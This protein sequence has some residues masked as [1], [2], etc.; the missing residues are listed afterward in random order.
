GVAGAGGGLSWP[1]QRAGPGR[2]GC[3]HDT[4]LHDAGTVGSSR[5]DAWPDGAVWPT[6]PAS[7]RGHQ[8]TPSEGAGAGGEPVAGGW[9]DRGRPAAGGPTARPPS[10]NGGIGRRRPSPNGGYGGGPTGR[11]LLGDGAGGR[12]GRRNSCGKG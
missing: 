7:A 10:P 8:A 1:G 11:P 9:G 4:L 12:A 5:P 2:A 6:A 3:P